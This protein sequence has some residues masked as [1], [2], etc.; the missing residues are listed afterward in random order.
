[1]GS[2]PGGLTDAELLAIFFGSGVVGANVIE[3]SRQMLRRYGSLTAISRCGVTEL[4]QQ[5]GIGQAK[6]IHLVAACELGRRLAQE[7]FKEDPLDTPQ[8][9]AALL[10]PEMRM[11]NRESLRVVL[12]NAR[13]KHMTTEEISLGSISEVTAHVN[14]ILRPVL[15]HAAPAFAVVHNHPSGDATPSQADRAFTRRLREAAEIM[16]VRFLDHIIIGQQ[17]AGCPEGYFSFREAGLL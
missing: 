5:K 13:L 16:Q 7:R 1:M 11:L 10:G 6:A 15:V 3:V 14:M 8:A 2:G 17:G 12:L 4:M 9:L